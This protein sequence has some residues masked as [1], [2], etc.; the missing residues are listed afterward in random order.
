[1]SEQV[2]E[3][4]RG[5]EILANVFNTMGRK[6]NR[7]GNLSVV[8][9]LQMHQAAGGVVLT[10]G[11][12]PSNAVPVAVGGTSSGGVNF[13]V[14]F[15]DG[16]IQ[17]IAGGTNAA[18]SAIGSSALGF[19]NGEQVVLANTSEIGTSATN[20]ALASGLITA[21]LILTGRTV[22]V[23]TAT[24]R[25]VMIDRLGTSNIGTVVV[26]SPALVGGDLVFSNRANVVV[27]SAGVAG[28]SSVAG[29]NCAV[30]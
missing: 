14:G 22:P 1:M 15:Y 13:G 21:G 19:S 6:V 16:H 4:Q 20:H 30:A 5:D 27:V 24:R 29:T 12:L 8:A 28:T 26:G 3:V 25:L 9:P 17:N 7:F 18:T 2:P 11:H 23:G 10:I